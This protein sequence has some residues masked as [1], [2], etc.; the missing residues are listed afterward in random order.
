M[1]TT[2]HNL[3]ND[4]VIVDNPQYCT[5]SGKTKYRFIIRIGKSLYA[6]GFKYKTEYNARTAGQTYLNSKV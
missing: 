4:Y 5:K 1:P 6:S 2:L 3:A